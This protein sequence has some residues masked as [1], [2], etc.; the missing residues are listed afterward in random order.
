VLIIR[1]FLAFGRLRSGFWLWRLLGSGLRRLGF[2]GLLTRFWVSGLRT[3]RLLRI[4][5]GGRLGSWF[6]WLVS[7]LVEAFSFLSGFTD[8]GRDEVLMGLVRSFLAG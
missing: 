5:L 8:S 7:F 3:A 4:T 2:T 6:L 1:L